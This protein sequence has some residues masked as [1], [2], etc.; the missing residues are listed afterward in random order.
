M[1]LQRIPISLA[2][3][4]N[5]AKEMIIPLRLDFDT[6]GSS[7]PPTNFH[8]MLFHGANVESFSRTEKKCLLGR[9][10]RGMLLSTRSYTSEPLQHG[11]VYVTFLINLVI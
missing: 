4:Y 11:N 2:V 6:E 10:T 3:Y 5:H 1:E 9:V 8:A 7:G